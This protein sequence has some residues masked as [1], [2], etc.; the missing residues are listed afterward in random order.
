MKQSVAVKMIS[1]TE[2]DGDDCLAPVKKSVISF[3]GIR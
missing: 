2:I 3:D 1:A